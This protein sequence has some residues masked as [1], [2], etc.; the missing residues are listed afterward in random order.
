MSGYITGT[1]EKYPAEILKNR[2]TI[3]GNVI[4]CVWKDPLLID[5][6]KLHSADFLTED[7]AFYFAL[8]RHLRKKGFSVFD[9]VTVLSNISE[10]VEA[11]WNGRG[12]FETIKNL[13]DIINLEN[14]DA[15][16]DALY[17]EN[18]II[19]LHNSGFNLLKKIKEKGKETTPLEIFRKMSSEAVIDW[20]E[21]RLTSFGTGYTT[22]VLE[23]EELI[24]DDKFLKD[25]EEGA[26]N[27]VPFDVSGLDIEGNEIKCLPFLSNQINGFMDG[28]LS[29]LGGYSSTGKTALWITVVMGLIH[30]GKKVLI[31]SNEQK[32]KV[33]KISFLVWILYKYFK[34]YSLTKK[35]ILSGDISE[36]DRNI[37]KQAQLFWNE[38]F[39]GKVKFIA[40]PD[41]DISL[42]KKKVRENVL[43][44][45]YD[46]ILYDTLKLDFNDKD[47]QYYLSLIRDSRELD[48]LAKKYNVII[49]CSL[50]LAIGT[51]GKLF[52]DST[53]LSMSKQIKEILENL[54]LMRNTYAEEL[55]L[56]NKKYY[57]RPF[58]RKNINGK[59]VEE[60]YEVD[61]TGIYK[62]LFIDKNRN[63]FNSGDTGICFL[64]K[65][66]GACGVFKEVA[67]AR[68]KH[69]YIS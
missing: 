69:G 39:K 5:E 29:I 10:Q 59:W 68:V 44:H 61:P 8:A 41:A 23:E 2:K 14:F 37:I 25:C 33:F 55:D 9:E 3:E 28:T 17:R 1:T 58:L 65:F 67:Y 45:D 30:R 46:V 40:I 11:A 32:C 47:E 4:A 22:R 62:F 43:R 24:I 31:I 7:G 27:G 16:A 36:S 12:G 18:I 63:G 50:Q 38:N 56:G 6:I 26:E 21:Y 49:L 51:L 57:C 53:V 48:K 34:C 19:G 64:Y 42:V 66:N 52:L 13:T 54:F 20:Y 60:P 35:K 15:Y